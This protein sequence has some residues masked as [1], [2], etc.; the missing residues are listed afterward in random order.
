MVKW[1]NVNIQDG[2]LGSHLENLKITSAPERLVG[3]SLN[4]MAG[5]GWGGGGGS[6]GALGFMQMRIIKS[7]R[8]NIHDGTATILKFFKAHLPLNRKSD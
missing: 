4:L 5:V 6:G 8:S 1:F 2:H 7:F 3:L